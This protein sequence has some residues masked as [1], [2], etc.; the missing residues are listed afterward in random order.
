[1]AYLQYFQATH[2]EDRIVPLTSNITAVLTEL[3]L[4]FKAFSYARA[5]GWTSGIRGRVSLFMIGGLFL[6]GWIANAGMALGVPLW[7][8]THPSLYV[9]ASRSW[10]N[11]AS[12]ADMLATGER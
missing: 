2:A 12:I 4:A 3:F 1:M 11:G 10:F 8:I 7:A 6:I 9:F 5:M